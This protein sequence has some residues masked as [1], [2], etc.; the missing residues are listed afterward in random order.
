MLPIL[1]EPDILGNSESKMPNTEN[2]IRLSSVVVC[3]EENLSCDLQGEAVIL[4]LK[5]GTYFGLNPLGA[6]IWELIKE[7]AKVSDVHQELLKEYE[8]DPSQCEMELLSFLK[9][10]QANDLIE[11]QGPTEP[12]TE[13]HPIV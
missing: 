3:A 1:C 7:P 9:Q 10:L 2:E 12:D 13:L 6:R 11:V 4:N 5:S 8:V